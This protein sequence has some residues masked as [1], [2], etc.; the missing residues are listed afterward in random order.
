MHSHAPITASR[1]WFRL[2]RLYQRGHG[3][4]SGRL[5]EV[6]LSPAQFDVLST[7]SEREGITQRE[8]AERLY[9]TKGNVSGLIDRLVASHYV[10]RR[11]IPEDRRSHS[12][13]ITPAGMEAIRVGMQVQMKFIEDTMGM[14]S[15]DDLQTMDRIFVLWRDRIREVTGDK[16]LGE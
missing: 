11:A 8:L 15:P 5:R 6:G 13:Y 2:L 16:T 14:L 12:L 9:V 4:I 1:L 10:E 3:A 7:L